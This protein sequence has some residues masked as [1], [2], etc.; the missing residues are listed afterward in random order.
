MQMT[1]KII[2]I[3]LVI[4]L[5]TGGSANLT[6]ESQHQQVS[7]KNDVE[8]ALCATPL[9][10]DAVY[11]LTNTNVQIKA[12]HFS[13]N[14]N[15]LA[16]AYVDNVDENNDFATYYRRSDC[17]EAYPILGTYLD[18]TGD[19][20]YLFYQDECPFGI[21]IL[22]LDSVG[23][24]I[25]T[26]ICR[27]MTSPPAYVEALSIE[28]CYM[29]LTCCIKEN[30]DF[31]IMGIILDSQ[32][33][34][35]VYPVGRQKGDSTIKYMAGH[36]CA[37]SL[38]D[39]FET[40]EEGYSAFREYQLERKAILSE[41]TI[42]PWNDIPFYES[43]YIREFKESIVT[44]QQCGD[45]AYIENYDSMIAIPLLSSDLNENIYILHLLYYHNQLIAEVVIERKYDGIDY[46][47]SSVWENVAKKNADGQ[48][49][50]L[51]SSQYVRVLNKVSSL[52]S[53]MDCQGVVYDNGQLFPVGMQEGKLMVFDSSTN[54]VAEYKHN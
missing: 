39:P 54:T 6:I 18:P 16:Q 32:G 12:T 42:Y 22:S 44:K 28:D 53:P 40:I 21:A 35:A 3:L 5:L 49:I 31:E 52:K 26:P 19:I 17:I 29:A 2:V 14:Y 7:N 11:Q 27:D 36:A 38:V 33:Y 4:S 34:P 10:A 50:P 8:I 51:E 1:S 48:Y 15:S 45:Y 43:G 24:V 13:L 46:T 47:Y 41:I 9:S 37:F 23:N 30:H 20:A 25:G